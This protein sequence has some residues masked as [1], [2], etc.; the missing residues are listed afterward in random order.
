M[1]KLIVTLS[2]LI[3]LL[4]SAQTKQPVY[5]YDSLG[6]QHY[7]DPAKVRVKAPIQHKRKRKTKTV[8]I[9]DRRKKKYTLKY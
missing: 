1:K 4:G 5:Y 8:I 6:N 9:V 7:Y 3:P 2:I